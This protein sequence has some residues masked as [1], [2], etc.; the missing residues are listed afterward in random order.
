M[1]V[2]IETQ[3]RE[4]KHTI[5]IC[6]CGKDAVWWQ[7]QLLELGNFNVGWWVWGVMSMPPTHRRAGPECRRQLYAIITQCPTTNKENQQTA[8]PFRYRLCIRSEVSIT[9][10]TR[11][12]IYVE[13]P[14]EILASQ[15]DWRHHR[16]CRRISRRA[17]VSFFKLNDFQIYIYICRTSDRAWPGNPVSWPVSLFGSYWY[18]FRNRQA[19]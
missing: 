12:T 3:F 6:P 19:N 13:Y 2:Y 7:M 18:S 8:A 4:R 9:K 10:L 17:R 14:S 5:A 11:W 15:A 1:S 16:T